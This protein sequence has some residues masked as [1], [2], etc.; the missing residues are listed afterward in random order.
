MAVDG[1]LTGVRWV[2]AQNRIVAFTLKHELSPQ[3]SGVSVYIQG[4][5]DYWSSPI[6]ELAGPAASH[7]L[8]AVDGV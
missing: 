6:A 4:M 7:E 1:R 3:F 2:L 5:L 8:T